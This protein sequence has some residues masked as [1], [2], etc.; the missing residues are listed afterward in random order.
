MG[1]VVRGLLGLFLGAIVGIASVTLLITLKYPNYYRDSGAPPL[2][3]GIFIGGPVG[4][5]MGLVA[6]AV[7]PVRKP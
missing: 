4:A 5:L 7:W 6:G 2:L 3:P 1:A